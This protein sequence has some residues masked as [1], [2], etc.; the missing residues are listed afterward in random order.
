MVAEHT[1][2]YIPVYIYHYKLKK[3]VSLFGKI[4]NFKSLILYSEQIMVT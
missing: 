1:H 2:K 3:E 4:I